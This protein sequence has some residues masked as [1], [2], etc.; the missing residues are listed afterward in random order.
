VVQSNWPSVNVAKILYQVRNW[1]AHW[2]AFRLGTWIVTRDHR[3]ESF[4]EGLI[5]LSGRLDGKI[6]KADGRVIDLGCLCRRVVTTAGVNY[7]RDDFAAAAGSADISNFKYHAIGTGSTA[8]AV[9]DTAMVTEVESRVA[10]TQV[11]FASKQYQSVA[12]IPITGTRAI[13]EHGLFSASSVGT[14]WDRSVFAV[15]NLVNG[16]SF[17]ATYTLTIND[18]G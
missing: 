6:I 15:I 14:L 16:D 17:Q 3:A 10:G 7:M 18:G 2:R 4:R 9:S 12:T 11:A 1:R 8:E 13:V 5:R